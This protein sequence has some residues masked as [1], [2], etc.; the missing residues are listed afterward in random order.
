MAILF[1]DRHKEHKLGRGRWDN[2]FCRFSFSFS[3]FRWEIENISAN[4]M[5]GRHSCF[6]DRPENTNLVEDVK[7]LRLIRM[8]KLQNWR[9]KGW[10]IGANMNLTAMHWI[11]TSRFGVTFWDK[12]STYIFFSLKSLLLNRVNAHSTQLIYILH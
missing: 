5:P 1:S 11:V 6:S 8:F 7:I 2:A 4:Q 10:F 9:L 3:G 12:K